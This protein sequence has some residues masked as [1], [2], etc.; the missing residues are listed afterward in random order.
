MVERGTLILGGILAL[1][2]T[3]VLIL[4]QIYGGQQ[5]GPPKKGDIAIVNPQALASGLSINHSAIFLNTRQ[6][7][8]ITFVAQVSAD[9]QVQSSNVT[10]APGESVP[11]SGTFFVMVPGSY[12]LT[13][14]APSTSGELAIPVPINVQVTGIPIPLSVQA[15]VTP[16][17]GNAP[18]TVTFSALASGGTE[19]YTFSWGFGDGSV[20]NEVNPTHTYL[21]SGL[22]S[23]SLSVSDSAFNTATAIPINITVNQPPPPPPTPLTMTASGSPL[24]GITPLVV[25][26]TTVIS[27]GVAPYTILW[28]FGDG[29][30]SLLQNPSHSY[31]QGTYTA[32]VTVVD[33]A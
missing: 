9:G 15:S 30:S 18:L 23:V 2:V 20:S 7:I 22:Y 13:W 1:G 3:G 5:G 32:S 11:T 25:N 24:L 6:D 17:S 27:G 14:V 28:N 8:S 21:L 12:T 10:L 16:I 29:S 33:S 26:F 4:R 19:P 31:T